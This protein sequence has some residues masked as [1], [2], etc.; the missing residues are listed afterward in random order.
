MTHL[1]PP[2]Q[3]HIS[4]LDHVLYLALHGDEEQDEE[5]QEQDGPKDRHVKDA[6]KGQEDADEEGLESGVPACA[7]LVQGKQSEAR[8]KSAMAIHPCTHGANGRL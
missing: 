2:G 7:C 3:G 1:F 6:E 4:V 8:G 5:V